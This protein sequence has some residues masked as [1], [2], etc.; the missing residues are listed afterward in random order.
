MLLYLQVI[1]NNQVNKTELNGVLNDAINLFH[2]P[3]YSSAVS[4]ISTWITNLVTTN[5]L[6]YAIIITSLSISLCLFVI[7]RGF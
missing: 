4:Q 7:G 1:A 5:Y 3:F 6:I 2:L